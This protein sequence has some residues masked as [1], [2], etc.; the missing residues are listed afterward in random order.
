MS[1]ERD[2]AEL[3]LKDKMDHHLAN[4]DTLLRTVLDIAA[5]GR[6]E[7]EDGENDGGDRFCAIQ[8]ILEIYRERH[9]AFIKE[10]FPGKA[11]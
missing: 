1:E 3:D 8:D 2:M 11:A 10:L 6:Q 9:T 5:M 4:T 7:M